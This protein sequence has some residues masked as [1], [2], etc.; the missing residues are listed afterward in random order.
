MTTHPKRDSIEI[1]SVT[2]EQLRDLIDDVWQH[3]T[4]GEGG[5][6]S[7]GTRDKL[8]DARLASQ[9]AAKNSYVHQCDIH[10]DYQPACP[11]CMKGIPEK[12]LA[13]QKREGE[14]E[15]CT[16]TPEEVAAIFRRTYGCDMPEL[17]IKPDQDRE[18]PP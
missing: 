17:K 7:T 18:V 12:I 9:L 15:S 1:F 4:E 5:Y 10:S 16:Y 14:Q 11:D 13:A 8:I 6:P 3:A 2:R